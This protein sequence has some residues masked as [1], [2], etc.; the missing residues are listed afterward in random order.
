M[1]FM[2]QKFKFIDNYI[3]SF[4]LEKYYVFPECIYISL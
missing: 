2:L 3:A 1:N 4:N